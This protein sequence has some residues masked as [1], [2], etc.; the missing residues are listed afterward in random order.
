MPNNTTRRDFQEL[1]ARY[2]AAVGEAPVQR[3]QDIPPP[4]YSYN[5]W[6]SVTA[7]ASCLGLTDSIQ[8]TP[9]GIAMEERETNR[10]KNL[11]ESFTLVLYDADD[12]SEEAKQKLAKDYMRLNR[13][14]LDQA[15][16]S[17]NMFL[18]SILNGEDII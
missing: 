11:I 8:A 16:V 3:E 7:P 17:I 14:V 10:I 1:Y 18:N 2:T 13:R 6:A 9:Y 4:S 5:P 12:I 15:G